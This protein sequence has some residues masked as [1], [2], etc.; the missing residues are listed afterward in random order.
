MN[1]KIL[2]FIWLLIL[3]LSS[4]SS[5]SQ[6]ARPSDWDE[7]IQQ[8][9]YRGV[10]YGKVAF[11]YLDPLHQDAGYFFIADKSL[12]DIYELKIKKKKQDRMAIQFRMGGKKIRAEFKGTVNDDTI[13]GTIKTRRGTSR[14]LVIPVKLPVALVLEKPVIHAPPPP[15][16]QSPVFNQVGILENISFGAASGYYT[17]MPVV[18]ESEYDY[19]QIILDALK[20]MFVHPGKDAFLNILNK[21]LISLAITDLQSLRLDLY[22]PVGDTLK[23]RPLVVLMHG[24]A[25]IIGDKACPTNQEL[26]HYFAAK[27]YVV[28]SI[29]YRLGFNPASKNSLERSAYRAVQDAR[30]ALRYLSYNAETYRIDPDCIFLGG[31]SAGAITALNTV[32]M[33]EDERLESTESNIWLL[34]KD[35]GGLDESTNNYRNSYTIKAVANLW[36]AVHDTNL[37]DREEHVPVVSFHGD[38]DKIVPC[39]CNYPF[40][41][42]DTLWTRNIICK[43]YGSRFIHRRLTN[44]GINS[45]LVILPGAGHEPQYEE[46]KYAMVMDTIAVRMT[47]FYNRAMFGFPE[48][49]GPTQVKAKAP[50]PIYSLPDQKDVR[51]YWQVNGGKILPGNI[52]SQ[53]RVVWLAEKTGTIELLMVHKNQANLEVNLPVTLPHNEANYFPV[54]K[55]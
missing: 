39:D 21:D 23:K 5:N 49:A 40:T 31:S 1:N 22:Q 26:A 37:I 42:L 12:P 27:G 28:A 14:R 38:A 9:W 17:S 32:F 8:N 18:G 48:I 54:R 11:V 45:E 35:L 41:D 13:S 51:Y 34:Q 46:G 53:V 10:V 52:K 30:A 47:G 15:R 29:N 3:T 2:A 50:L 55:R 36:G 24:G 16:Y 7:I 33:K 20:K 44:L 6:V 19:Q 43:M 4:L 25:F